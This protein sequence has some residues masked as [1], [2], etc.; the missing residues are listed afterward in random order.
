MDYSKGQV[1]FSKNGRTKG[2]ALMV[3]NIEDD[4]LHLADGGLWPLAKPKRKKPKHVQPTHYV[5]SVIYEKLTNNYPLTD[6]DI[7]KSLKE[8]EGKAS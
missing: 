6:S 7:R 1:V 2:K 5:D 4:Y 3:I 8:Y